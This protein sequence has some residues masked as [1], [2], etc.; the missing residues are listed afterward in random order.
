MPDDENKAYFLYMLGNFQN[1][2]KGS[3][4]KKPP[5]SIVKLAVFG[6]HD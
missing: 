4:N 3:G 6:A 1:D 2:L 5:T